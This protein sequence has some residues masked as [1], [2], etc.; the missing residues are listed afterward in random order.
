MLGGKNCLI[1]SNITIRNT[2]M[3]DNIVIQDGSK[4]GMKGFWLCSFKEKIL[5]FLILV[6]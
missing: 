2:I 4:I 1:G 3:G 5:D 6:G